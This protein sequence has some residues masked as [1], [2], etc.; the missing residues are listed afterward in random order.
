MDTLIFLLLDGGGQAA[1]ICNDYQVGRKKYD[2]YE[3]PLRRENWLETV[4]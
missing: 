1:A 2:L 4:T 3:N